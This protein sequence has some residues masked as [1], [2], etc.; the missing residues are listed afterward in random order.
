MAVFWGTHRRLRRSF[1]TTN[2][3]SNQKSS[4]GKGSAQHA[5][6][7]PARDYCGG[8]PCALLRSSSWRPRRS[9]RLPSQHPDGSQVT[10]TELDKQ[11]VVGS[12]ALTEAGSSPRP[13]SGEERMQTQPAPSTANLRLPDTSHHG[14][15]L[16]LIET[17]RPRFLI[18]SQK[19]WSIDRKLHVRAFSQEGIVDVHSGTEVAK[20]GG[21][22]CRCLCRSGAEQP[23]AFT[24]FACS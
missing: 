5:L 12:I 16:R 17:R 1:A 9:P 10:E 24:S 6:D 4:D 14:A 13:L 11:E 7:N 2:P 3:G 23:E 8:A 20:A 21:R 18:N 22:S 19:D 15:R